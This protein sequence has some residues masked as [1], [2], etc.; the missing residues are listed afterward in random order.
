MV[1]RPV[2]SQAGSMTKIFFFFWGG[3]A[4]CNCGDTV[5]T[6]QT[7]GE[8]TVFNRADQDK[9]STPRRLQKVDEA[10]DSVKP[11]TDTPTIVYRTIHQDTGTVYRY[12]ASA[13]RSRPRVL[14]GLNILQTKKISSKPYNLS[15]SFQFNFNQDLKLFF[16]QVILRQGSGLFSRQCK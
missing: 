9:K 1:V 7:T 2:S 10:L 14:P 15:S 12:P 11:S 16:K 4:R 6:E 13:A 3:G 5:V 8:T